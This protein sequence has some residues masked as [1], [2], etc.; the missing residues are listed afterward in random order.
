MSKNFWLFRTNLRPLEYYHQYKSLENFEKNCH[1]F[2]LLMGI[3]FLRNRV[4]DN[5]IVWRLN[6]KRQKLEDIV[7]DVDGKKFIQRWVSNFNEVFTHDP[8]KISFFRGGFPE[9]CKITNINSDHL[10]KKLYL[11]AGRR[12]FPQYGGKYDLVLLESEQ[13]KSNKYKTAPFYKTA[14]N[15][16][17]KPIEIP[18]KFNL[19]W[20]CNFAQI[21]HKGQEFFI[22]EISKSSH[23]KQLNI[24]HVGNKPEDGKRMCK[25]YGVN[26]INFAGWVD[27]PILNEYLNSSYFGVVTSNEV[28]GCPR[29][30]TEVMMSGTPLLLRKRTRLLGYYK[31]SG[32]IIFDDK[33]LKNKIQHGMFRYDKY[34]Q[35]ATENVQQKITMEKICNMNLHIWNNSKK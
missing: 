1:D 2:Y 14:N 5:F 23:L 20:I 17:F 7:F 25:R 10:G 3:W 31:K 32:I 12:V 18:K 34:K 21:R 24:I 30:I 9:Y 4:Y 33:S 15:E 6:P 29:V 26:N 22:R 19:C 35:E 16:I 28:D 27:R 13:D 11:G 8:P